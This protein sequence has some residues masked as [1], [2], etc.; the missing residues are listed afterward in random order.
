[1]KTKN[2]K[3]KSTEIIQLVP[4]MGYCIASDK[5]TV[6]GMMVGCMYR[7]KPDEKGD[8]GWSFF[9]G[10]ESQDY[11]DNPDNLGLY[12]VNTIANYDKTIIPYLDFSYGTELEKTNKT[13]EFQII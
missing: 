9:S 6:E 12:D 1:M 3:L 4:P 7:D 11:V 10:T 5:I 2:F 8:S 13:E